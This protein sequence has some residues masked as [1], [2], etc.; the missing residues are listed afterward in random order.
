[1]VV[2]DSSWCASVSAVSKLPTVTTSA[3]RRPQPRALFHR[4]SARADARVHRGERGGREGNEN[5][6]DRSNDELAHVTS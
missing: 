3:A 2:W 5:E 4:A 6:N 1:M